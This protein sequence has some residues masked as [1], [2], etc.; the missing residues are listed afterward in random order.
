MSL[1]AEGCPGRTVHGGSCYGAA[2]VVW[3][4]TIPMNLP[5]VQSVLYTGEVQKTGETVNE[6]RVYH[7]IGPAEI[8]FVK[9][10]VASRF[11][12]T[13]IIGEIIYRPMAAIDGRVEFGH[14]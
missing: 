8:G 7:F 6:T 10:L 5:V 11:A 13:T 1:L 2:A 3:E 9:A 12:H 14:K 4:V